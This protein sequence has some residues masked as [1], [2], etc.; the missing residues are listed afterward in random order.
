[1]LVFIVHNYVLLFF[2][3]AENFSE[4]ESNSEEQNPGFK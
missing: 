2:Q 1:M 4:D 3:N